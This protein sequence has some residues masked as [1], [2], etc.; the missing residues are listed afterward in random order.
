MTTSD[1]TQPEK[2]DAA[3]DAPASDGQTR[4]SDAADKAPED[5]TVEDWESLLEFQRNRAESNFNGWQ[6]AQADYA[7]HKRRADQERSDALR[8][9]G[10]PALGQAIS[11]ADD[12]DRALSALPVTLARL[13]WIEGVVI[14]HR[15]LL[16]MLE[17]SGVQEIEAEGKEFD[18][19]VHEAIA[20]TDGPEGQVIQVVQKGYE[21]YGRVLRPSLV[22]VGKGTG[23]VAEDGPGDDEANPEPGETGSETTENR[24]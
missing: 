3:A 5:R 9:G 2:P 21:L 13:T 24:E 23:P 22:Q 17:A 12:L 16:A 19:N 20:Q 8:Y 4:E 11:I 18:P 7:N 6:R 14:I 15:K 10:A 1:E